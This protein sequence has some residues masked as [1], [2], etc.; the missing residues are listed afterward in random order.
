[1]IFLKLIPKFVHLYI[2]AIIYMNVLRLV[3]FIPRIGQMLTGLFDPNNI[4]RISGFDVSPK[5]L[6]IKSEKWSIFVNV[7][8]H[9]GYI[10]F[11]HNRP[12]EMSLYNYIAKNFNLANSNRNITS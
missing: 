9:I 4:R 10:S 7:R 5:L 3:Y 12:F 11:I 2:P 6:K 1:M 8:D